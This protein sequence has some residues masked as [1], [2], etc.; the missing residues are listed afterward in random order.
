MFWHE[1][2]IYLVPN[3][4][5]N[6]PHDVWYLDSLPGSERVNR[7]VKRTRLLDDN[8]VEKLFTKV[9]FSF[10][11]NASETYLVSA[12]NELTEADFGPLQPIRAINALKRFG[13]EILE[14]AKRERLC[15]FATVMNELTDEWKSRLGP[16]VL[17]FERT[18]FTRQVL[19][20]EDIIFI[21]YIIDA[22][23]E[24]NPASIVR[25]NPALITNGDIPMDG[26]YLWIIDESG[27][28]L[29][30]E[31]TRNPFAA[32]KV[33]CHTNITGGEK[34]YQGGECWFGTDNNVYINNRS[35]RYGAQTLAQRNAI[36]DYFRAMGYTPIQLSL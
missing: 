5:L 7:T 36:L 4:Y 34:A 2:R 27:L 32:R 33:V 17:P 13:L 23:R 18:Q 31:S 9:P 15:S 3:R 35:G 6:N 25:T 10:Y 16:A 24:G 20:G 30:A 26:K 11:T 21:D 28:K 8:T 22:G 14:K 1:T 19:D 29:L 12:K